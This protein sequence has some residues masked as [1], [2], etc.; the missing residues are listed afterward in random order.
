MGLSHSARQGINTLW[1]G[2]GPL[3]KS[4]LTHRKENVQACMT[5]IDRVGSIREG[6]GLSTGVTAHTEGDRE[7]PGDGRTTMTGECESAKR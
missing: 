2:G 4:V 3:R 7:F 1:N 5:Q 6:E